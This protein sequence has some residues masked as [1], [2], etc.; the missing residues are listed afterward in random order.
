[1]ED[2]LD[3]TRKRVWCSHDYHGLSVEP[4]EE[5]PL[6]D[7]VNSDN[8][9]L[10]KV[11]L[12]LGALCVEINEH[13]A[14]VRNHFLGPLCIFG[15]HPSRMSEEAAKPGDMEVELGNM[16]F[17]FMDLHSFCSRLQSLC[18]NLVHQLAALYS[19]NQKLYNTTFRHVHLRPAFEA[20]GNLLM[21][22]AW[23]D[24]CIAKSPRLADD[25]LVAFR[26]MVRNMKNEPS[27]YGVT[28]EKL[29]TLEIRLQNLDDKLLTG[30]IFQ[31]CLS[32]EFDVPNLLGVTNNKVFLEEFLYHLQ[33]FLTSLVD[34]VDSATETTQRYQ[35]VSTC[36]LYLLYRRLT[37]SQKP[38][39]KLFQNLWTV[40]KASPLVHVHGPVMM[41]PLAFLLQHM[42]EKEPLQKVKPGE[43]EGIAKSYLENLVANLPKQVHSL[44]LQVCT[45]MVRIESGT[46]PTP[47]KKD[48]LVKRLTLMINGIL[49]AH[50]TSRLL[51]TCLV[52]HLDLQLPFTKN[53]I[54]LLS[55][56]AE[57]LKAIET[58]YHHKSAMAGES[59]VHMCRQLSFSLQNVFLRGQRKLEQKAAATR[60]PSDETIDQ[61]A[62]LGLV[63]RMLNG[64]N[65]TT[66]RAVLSLALAV[67][68]PKN[69]LK[70]SE[71]EDV[72]HI[73]WK[74]SLL[75]EWQ[76][77][78]R[79][80]CDTSFLYWARDTLPV[81]LQFVY[82]NPVS[83]QR[84]PYLIA[85]YSEGSFA[86]MRARHL[87]APKALSQW[88]QD[89][90]KETLYDIVILPFAREIETDLRLSIHAAVDSMERRN[91]FKHRL[92]EI[93][94]FLR[95][96]AFRVFDSIMDPRECVIHYLDTVFYN[97]TTLTP[98]DWKTY[99]EMRNLAQDK[100]G[101]ELT[102]VYLP[103]ATLEQ[104]L[105]V[106]EIMRNIHIFVANYH[107]NLNNQIF[108]QKITEN[109]HVNTIGIRHIANSI[110]THG[111][112]IINTTVNYTYQ[113]LIQKLFIFSQFLFDDHIK[114]PCM[115]SHKWFK[116]NKEKL[117]NQ[118][119]FD[120]ADNFNRH[121]RKLGVTEDG[122]TFLD[123]FRVLITE[124][125][126]AMGYVRMV[127][128]GGQHYCSNAI[129]FVPDLQN[130][131]NFPDMVETSGLATETLHSAKNLN[132]MIHGLLDS[133]TEGT[134]FFKALVDVF[135]EELGTEKNSHL[136]YFYIITPPLI[137]NFLEYMVN[138]KDT[139]MKR[140][141]EGCFTDDGFAMGLAYLLQVLHQTQK[142]DSLHWFDTLKEH[143]ATLKL[144]T[145][146]QEEALKKDKK[147]ASNTAASSAAGKQDTMN[148]SAKR[149]EAFALEVELF[150][151]SFSGARIFFNE[152]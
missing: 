108:V 76:S 115:K 132:A 82:D 124:I 127:R 79:T 44:Y 104:G 120:R 27:R 90:I 139:L 86:A 50:H 126:N 49:L 1:M 81:C 9:P 60:H 133:F 110:R 58:A 77:E 111:T 41:Q 54:F 12:V 142:F 138:S 21:V 26:R 95:L 16:L 136:Q 74:F 10:S 114:S 18:V 141:K 140:S 89:H 94:K 91:P 137:I 135:R 57:I 150:Y 99:G 56:L 36:C 101:L 24:E 62:S 97:L 73:M 116:D 48:I 107:Y 33:H 148:L 30:S 83:S 123:Q 51:R 40:C 25:G 29:R 32:Q 78:L 130:I 149:V 43:V 69:V 11:I 59:V 7:L 66:R 118:F 143:V 75:S 119:P 152:N 129:K 20:L 106:L 145:S 102:E 47:N 147:T 23:I 92:R 15:D 109:K 72:K 17:L 42:N 105:D 39:K 125:G 38:N 2:T 14:K 68:Q 144:Q 113:F 128:S 112:G 64:P 100:F 34:S 87:E 117:N 98:Q 85:A 8:K 103:G 134:D 5:T 121:I 31:N 19:P 151:Y 122:M 46:E 13:K 146:S 52:G 93:A 84:L 3:Q 96:G 80:C 55:T 63:L 67:T 45:W 53:T 71:V 61:L 35:V 22:L 65:T 4:H 88:Y 70:E 28:E 37:I 131:A 6:P